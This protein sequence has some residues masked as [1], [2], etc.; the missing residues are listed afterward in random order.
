MRYFFTF[1]A[2]SPFFPLPRQGLKENNLE[3]SLKKIQAEP[4]PGIPQTKDK[5]GAT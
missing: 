4:T 1:M 5:R 3:S 2:A